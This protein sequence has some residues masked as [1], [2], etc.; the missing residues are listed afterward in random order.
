[1]QAEVEVVSIKNAI[2]EEFVL[3]FCAAFSN[4]KEAVKEQM[5]AAKRN[6]GQRDNM[7]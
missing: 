7:I 5:K 6:P 3:N 4:V 2:T 1:M